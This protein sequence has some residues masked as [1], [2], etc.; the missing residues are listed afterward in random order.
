MS[1]SGWMKFP[2]C[3]AKWRWSRDHKMNTLLIHLMNNASVCDDYVGNDVIHRGQLVVTREQICK[4]TGLSIQEYRTRIKRLILAGKITLISTNE[5]TII[6]ICDLADSDG[7]QQLFE[8]SVT[9]QQPTNNQRITNDT[10][11]N[12]TRDYIDYNK[13]NTHTSY[14]RNKNLI[15]GVCENFVER[16]NRE[17]QSLKPCTRLTTYR[18]AMIESCL[19]N[20][21]EADVEKF[22]T[23]LHLSPFLSGLNQTGFVADIS[24]CLSHFT[25]ILEGKYISSK[26]TKTQQAVDIFQESESE[27]EKHRREVD[28]KIKQ[29]FAIYANAQKNPSSTDAELIRTWIQSGFIA[30]NNGKCIILQKE[31]LK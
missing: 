25:E 5:H 20:Y 21:S 8:D 2:R 11:I 15:S 24:F 6:T 22:F 30:D 23:Q 18:R 10:Y 31:Q 26:E 14:K 29:I 17:F 19:N 13:N 16:Y 9:N 7:Q 4:E 3:F 12:N 27:E 1:G 28:E